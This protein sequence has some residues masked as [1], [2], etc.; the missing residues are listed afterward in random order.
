MLTEAGE[1]FQQKEEEIEKLKIVI[2]EDQEKI[3]N[4]VQNFLFC[5]VVTC[6][7]P[8]NCLKCGLQVL[9]KIF[10]NYS[11]GH[12]SILLHLVEN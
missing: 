9:E 4:Q 8:P 5:S 12:D 3:K 7:V 6:R 11:K 10:Y 2:L 1:T